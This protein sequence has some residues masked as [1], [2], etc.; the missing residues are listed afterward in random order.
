LKILRVALISTGVGA[1]VVAF[2]SLIAYLTATKTGSELLS[3]GFNA[4]GATIN[5]LVE[6]V[7]LLGSAVVKFFN[8]DYKG[9][10][11]DAKAAIKDVVIEIVKEVGETDKLTKRKQALADA[12]RQLNV[13]SAEQRSIIEGLKKDGDD[14]TRSIDERLSKTREAAKLEKELLSAKIKNAKEAIAIGA[15]EIAMLGD[16]AKADKLDEQAELQIELYGLK[17][18]S[19]TLQT[20]LQN[21]ENGLAK[22]KLDNANAQIKKFAELSKSAVELGVALELINEKDAFDIAKQEQIDV[23]KKIKEETILLGESMKKD[24]VPQIQLLDE[25]IEKISKRQFRAIITVASLDNV[26]EEVDQITSTEEGEIEIN[27]KVKVEL[28]K[29]R[30]ELKDIDNFEDL[31]DKLL[32]DIFGTKNADRIGEFLKGAGTLLNEFGALANEATAIQLEAIDKQL[33]KL[34]EK[35]E[36]LQSDLD[37]ELDAQS[38]GLANNVGNKQEEVDNIL[39]EETRLE[40]ERATIQA[41]AQKRQLALETAQQTAGL[42]TSSINIYKSFTASL[43]VLGPVLAVAAIGSMFALFA[44]TKAKAFK[45]T[46]LS[47]GADKINDH[48]GFGERHGETDLEGRGDGYELVNRRTGRSTNTIISGKE[49]LLPESVSLANSEFFHSMRNGL[50]SGINLNDAMGF[51][52]THNGTKPK[53]GNIGGVIR[54]KQVEAKRAP[55]RQYIPYVNKKGEWTAKLVTISP[56]DKDGNEII[57]KD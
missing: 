27:A 53:S 15:A 35:R 16:L 50:Y 46:K 30:D 18:D 23:I 40:E 5:V 2:G 31:F 37:A 33:N 44:A 10:A 48:F 47:S 7:A 24:V 51:Y 57:F 28:P 22:E 43:G 42:I 13:R 26:Q 56:N 3:R 17:E 4:V 8:R 52:M 20:E 29:S 19:L 14:V 41:A 1:I 49:M 54:T 55:E 38:K 11:E 32:D 45:A 9:A 34:G 36:D 25:S 39:A 21:S 12:Q 6:R